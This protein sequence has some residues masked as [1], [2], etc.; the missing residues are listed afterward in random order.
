VNARTEQVD[1][2]RLVALPSAVNCAELFARFALAE[3]SLRPM[4]EE[5][6]HVLGSLVGSVVKTSNHKAPRFITLRLRLSGN[7]LVLE[8]ECDPHSPRPAATSALQGRHTGVLQL[9]DGCTLLWCELPLPTGMTA[10]AVPLPRRERRRSPAAENL[11]PEATEVD[12]QVMERLLYGLGGSQ[13]WQ[14]D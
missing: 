13:G 11:P 8:V 4:Q 5:A 3:W 9:D 2:L 12:P 6:A 10:S 7:M 1:D 14:A